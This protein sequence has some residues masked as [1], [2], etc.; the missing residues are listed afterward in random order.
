MQRF[1]SGLEIADLSVTNS[2]KAVVDSFINADCSPSITLSP[3]KAEKR[4]NIILK[5][6]FISSFDAPNCDDE[7]ASNARLA[8]K[9]KCVAEGYRCDGKVYLWNSFNTLSEIIK[10]VI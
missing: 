3:S 9:L 6:I 5:E 1:N 4:K 10:S 7:K 2:V 8:K